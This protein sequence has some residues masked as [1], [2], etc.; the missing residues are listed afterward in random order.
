MSIG[1]DYIPKRLYRFV[2]ETGRKLFKQYSRKLTC[3]WYRNKGYLDGSESDSAV[4][5]KSRANG[6]A[7]R[8]RII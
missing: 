6:E 1:N 8:L 3:I 5:S 7:P 2:E 4:L